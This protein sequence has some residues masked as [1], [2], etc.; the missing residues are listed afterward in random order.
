MKKNII[1]LSFSGKPELMAGLKKK[2]E[3][4][5]KHRV[6]PLKMGEYVYELIDKALKN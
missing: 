4:V 6:Q 1:T 2:L 3:E 5:N